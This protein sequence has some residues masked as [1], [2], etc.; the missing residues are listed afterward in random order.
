MND[1]RNRLSVRLRAARIRLGAWYC[2]QVARD[3][4]QWALAAW[5]LAVSWSL[6]FSAGELL[7]QL[8]HG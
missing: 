5:M 8:V 3:V 6:C 1:P 4:P 7:Y 2:R